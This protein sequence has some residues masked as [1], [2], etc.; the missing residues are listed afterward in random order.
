MRYMN[1]TGAGDSLLG[2]RI[3]KHKQ[4]NSDGEKPSTRHRLLFVGSTVPPTEL[5]GQE[6]RRN[7]QQRKT[8]KKRFFDLHGRSQEIS[9]P[10]ERDSQTRVLKDTQFP[11]KGAE[12]GESG[13]VPLVRRNHRRSH[14]RGAHRNQR[15]IC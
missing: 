11:L 7:P 13:E 6:G 3:P 14:S 15:I 9:S 5:A 2:Q 10:H 12:F 4:R 1:F 8:Q